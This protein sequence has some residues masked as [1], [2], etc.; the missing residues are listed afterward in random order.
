MKNPSFAEYYILNGA[1]KAYDLREEIRNWGGYYVPEYKCWAIASPC[2][3]AKRVLKLV[4][5]KLQFRKLI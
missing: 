1:S 5:L 4:G 2:E 3:K